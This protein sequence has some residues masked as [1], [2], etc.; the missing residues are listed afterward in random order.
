MDLDLYLDLDLAQILMCI[1]EQ[2]DS[3]YHIIV[4]LIYQNLNLDLDLDLDQY[5]N[6]DL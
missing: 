4:L 3:I 2:V 1:R 6:L 5:L